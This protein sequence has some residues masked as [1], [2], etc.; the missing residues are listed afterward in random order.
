MEQARLQRQG[1]VKVPRKRQQAEWET[2]I[3]FS[4]SAG[5]GSAVSAPRPVVFRRSIPAPR[6]QRPRIDL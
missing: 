5:T 4:A 3:G 1:D 6:S 2:Q